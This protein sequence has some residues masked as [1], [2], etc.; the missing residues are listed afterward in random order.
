[1]T[2]QQVNG[3]QPGDDPTSLVPEQAGAAA[4]GGTAGE[5]KWAV[6]CSGGGIRSEAYHQ[7]GAAAVLG[8]AQ[9][10]EPPLKRGPAPAAAGGAQPAPAQADRRRALRRGSL[11]GPR[12]TT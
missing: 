3:H 12:K 2:S 1:M 5:E 10:C 4:A 11:S 7:L 6:C 8:A 9:D